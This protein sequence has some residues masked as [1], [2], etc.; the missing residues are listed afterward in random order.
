MG[1]ERQ[2]EIVRDTQE[3]SNFT[4]RICRETG[5]KERSTNLLKLLIF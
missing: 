2:L 4:D 5:K 1:K 3:G